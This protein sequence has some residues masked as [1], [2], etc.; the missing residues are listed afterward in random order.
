M[1]NFRII[2]EDYKTST[3]TRF[4]EIFEL[5]SFN[6]K[7][8]MQATLK[9]EQ[10]YAMIDKFEFLEN[11]S[12]VELI[13]ELTHYLYLNFG[14]IESMPAKDILAF[15]YL[16]F[17]APNLRMPDMFVAITHGV[18][19]NTTLR[20]LYENNRRVATQYLAAS[21]DLIKDGPIY[22]M[23]VSRYDIKLDADLSPGEYVDWM[24]TTKVDIGDYIKGVNATKNI[25]K[26]I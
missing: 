14:G 17:A 6:F 2:K 8:G 12:Q 4:W 16:L 24:E 11:I 1:E 23:V 20:F 5:D 18:H 26:L 25:Q 22:D 7:S 10:V 19:L 15:S 9:V 13:S 3:T 21:M